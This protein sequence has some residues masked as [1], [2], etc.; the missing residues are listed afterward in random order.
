MTKQRL[1]G[2][3]I[4]FSA[5][6]L[7]IAM[8][9]ACVYINVYDRNFYAATYA[10]LGIA[11]NTGMSQ[12]D[13]LSATDALLLYCQGKRADLNVTVRVDGNVQQV[14]NQR[15]SEHMKDVRTLAQNGEAV[16]NALFIA[17]AVL[18]ILG[19]AIGKRSFRSLFK[20]FLW[21]LCAGVALMGITALF[22]AVDFDSF[23]TLFHRLLFTNELWLL[24][25]SDSIL[26]NM[27]PLEF[28]FALVMRILL[29]YI[30]AVVV[31][32]GA[33]VAGIRIARRKGAL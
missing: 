14:F 16:R 22:A 27:V 4:V 8:L 11:Q 32:G 10:K 17:F 26:I 25:A 1:S 20:P 15:E 28:F 31:L 5:F 3:M 2:A 18:L 12:D 9:L 33:C 13:L 19:I 7:S 29:Y 23:W 21:G 24:D 30:G 6:C